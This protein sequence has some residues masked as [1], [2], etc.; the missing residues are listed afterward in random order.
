[1]ENL[2]K[3]Y[4]KSVEK[5]MENFWKICGKIYGKSVENLWKSMKNQSMENLWKICGNHRKCVENQ[6]KTG[7]GGLEVDGVGR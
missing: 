6:G 7:F 5:S 2:L 3:I 1:M 4:G